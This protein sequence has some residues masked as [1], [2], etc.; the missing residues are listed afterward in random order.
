MEN[1][2]SPTAPILFTGMQV[3]VDKAY[4]Q[5]STPQADHFGMDITEQPH[6]KP[7]ELTVGIARDHDAES[8]SESSVV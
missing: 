8:V 5:L 1:S 3:A 2:S 6:E 4:E 7:R